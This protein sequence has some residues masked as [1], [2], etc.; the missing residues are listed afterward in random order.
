MQRN[1][2][3]LFLLPALLL[4]ACGGGR[5]EPPPTLAAQ[6]PSATPAPSATPESQPPA[7]AAA[8]TGL[9]GQVLFVLDPAHS[10]V[11]FSVDEILRNAPATAVGVTSQVSG[12]IQVDFDDPSASQV[13]PITVDAATLATDSSSRNGM[14][15]RFILDTAAFPTITFTPT[16]ISGLPAQVEVGVVYDVSITGDLTIR[17]VTATETFTGQVT[18]VSETELQGYFSAVVLRGSVYGLQIPSVP[19][20][21]S[22]DDNVLLEI[23]FVAVRQ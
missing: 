16:G 1:L 14:I 7:Q 3:V 6:E 19:Q 4:A 13:G 5:A 10:Q 22:V 11:S 2:M 18:L 8:P 20:V 12:E 21:A 17:D 9:S 23:R 15:R